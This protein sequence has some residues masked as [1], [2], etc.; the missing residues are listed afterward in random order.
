M[1][2]AITKMSNIHFAAA[3]EYKKRI[4]QLGEQP[5]RVFNV[6]ALGLDHIQRTKFKSISELSELYDFDFSKPYFLITYHPE[7]NLLEE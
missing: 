5:E 1:R 3:E 2:H 7:T 6:G 4:I